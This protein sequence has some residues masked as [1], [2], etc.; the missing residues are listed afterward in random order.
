MMLSYVRNVPSNMEASAIQR[1]SA[2]IWCITSSLTN[3]RT[4]V[5]GSDIY[6]GLLYLLTTMSHEHS[7][8]IAIGHTHQDFLNNVC[9]HGSLPIALSL[10]KICFETVC[11][12]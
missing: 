3:D 7:N 2:G 8:A 12:K 1:L 6:I 4:I 10:E 5:P 9:R 11:L